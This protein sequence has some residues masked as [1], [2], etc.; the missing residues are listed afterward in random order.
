M[1]G[2]IVATHDSFF[3]T[4]GFS[5][6]SAGAGTLLTGFQPYGPATPGSGG[7]APSLG[8]SGTP[9]LGT[10]V[11]LTIANAL[12]GALAVLAASFAGPDLRVFGSTTI[13]VADPVVPS[14]L[15]TSGPVG[16]PGVGSASLV[17]SIPN[18]AA[19]VG[20]RTN[21]QG[22]VLDVG[23]VDGFSATAGLEMWIQ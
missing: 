1:S 9:C 4:F 18:A 7:I 13:L 10:S 16:A 2:G 12:G 8:H 3:A 20:L 6:P 11:S 5:G 15:F 19:F 14:W 17:F 22:F 21:L 23:A